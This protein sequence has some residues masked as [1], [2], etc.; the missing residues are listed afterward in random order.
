MSKYNIANSTKEQREKYVVDAL[1]INS[2]G[3][4]PLTKENRDLLQSYVDGKIELKDLRK[5]II[6]KYKKH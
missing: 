6:N 2:L 1:A 3:A 4:E 5:K